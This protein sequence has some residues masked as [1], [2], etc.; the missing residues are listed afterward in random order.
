MVA[1]SGTSAGSGI[2]V[3]SNTGI[4]GVSRET[5]KDVTG[6]S[7]LGATPLPFPSLSSRHPINRRDAIKTI[8]KGLIKFLISPQLVKGIL[9]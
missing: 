6:G 3:V 8:M 5:G 1:G 7:G 2:G 9:F 4:I